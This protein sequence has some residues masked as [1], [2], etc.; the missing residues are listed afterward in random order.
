MGKTDKEWLKIC[1]D[2]IEVG[3][4]KNF[5]ETVVVLVNQLD[6]GILNKSR[7]VCVRVICVEIDYSGS[8]DVV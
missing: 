8:E 6:Y 7:F 3:L 4:N 1:N 5:V 2:R